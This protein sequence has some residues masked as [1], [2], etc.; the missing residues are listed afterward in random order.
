MS[1]QKV[2]L[3]IWSLIIPI[4]SKFARKK[5]LSKV[6]ELEQLG[7]TQFTALRLGQAVR[8]KFTVDH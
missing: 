4:S 8:L 2:W 1:D 3:I 7:V 6:W 5:S